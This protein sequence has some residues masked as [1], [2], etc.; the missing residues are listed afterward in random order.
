MWPST[1]QNNQRQNN[2]WYSLMLYN[3]SGTTID[4]CVQRRMWERYTTG[5]FHQNHAV[6]RYVIHHE[7]FARSRHLDDGADRYAFRLLHVVMYG[8]F[9]CCRVKHRRLFFLYTTKAPRL[10]QRGAF[11]VLFFFYKTWTF[12]VSLQV[13]KRFF[14]GTTTSI[15]PTINRCF[16]ILSGES[17]KKLNNLFPFFWNDSLISNTLPTQSPNLIVF[18]TL[19]SFAWIFIMVVFVVVWYFKST[20]KNPNSQHVDKKKLN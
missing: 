14:A 9:C 3:L 5:A 11:G 20:T 7:R 6:G 19:I 2:A 15:V 10:S 16:S 13:S 8:I 12:V 18:P 17:I 1:N 4:S